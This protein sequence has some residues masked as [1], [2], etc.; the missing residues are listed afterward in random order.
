MVRVDVAAARPPRSGD[1]CRARAGQRHAR[2]RSAARRRGRSRISPRAAASIWSRSARSCAPSSSAASPPPTR[3]GSN[4][5]TTCPRVRCSL[6]PTNS[7]TRCRSAN[8]CAG[9]RHWAERMVALD[10][11]G[12]ICRLST[13]PR[14][15][16]CRCSCP[17]R[18]AIPCRPASVFEICPPALALAVGARRAA[19]GP[20]RVRRCSSITAAFPSAAGASLRAVRRHR[21]VGALEAP[22]SADLSADVDFAA[23]AEAARAAGAAALRSGAARPFSA[24]RWAP[25]DGLPGL[26][27]RA[28]PVAAPSAW[29]AVSNAC[30]TRRK[31]A[32]CSR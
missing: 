13:D 32:P 12:A 22:G 31:W 27:A 28:A 26:S 6:S 30:S 16:R 5:R 18:C 8:W 25:A 19:R 3:S 21:P 1:P 20:S 9:V 11:D 10:P 17:R 29:R 4:G 2:R 23:F 7:S 24:T 14:A 15:R